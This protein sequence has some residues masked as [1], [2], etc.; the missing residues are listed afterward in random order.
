MGK[1]VRLWIVVSGDLHDFFN[2]TDVEKSEAYNTNTE[3]MDYF[4]ILVRKSFD[5]DNVTK[6]YRYES[7]ET[8]DKELLDIKTKM[9]ENHDVR[10]F[11]DEEDGSL[12]EDDDEI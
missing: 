7:K 6:K 3:Q 4:L 11:G 12:S 9:S 2:I 10:F 5:R 1:F 8:R